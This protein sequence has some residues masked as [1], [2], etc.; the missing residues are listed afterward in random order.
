MVDSAEELEQAKLRYAKVQ[1]ALDEVG[2]VLAAAE[3]A[4]A[5]ADHAREAADRAH[6]ALRK[7]LP[8]VAVGFGVLILLSL[9]RHHSQSEG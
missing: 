8:V 6:E 1:E 2:K 3:Q 7:L 9:R 4:Q 5:A